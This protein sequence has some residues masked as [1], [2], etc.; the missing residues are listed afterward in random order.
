MAAYHSRLYVKSTTP[1][2]HWR[3]GFHKLDGKPLT[4][5]VAEGV[6]EFRDNIVTSFETVMGASPFLLEEVGRNSKA[7]RRRSLESL[8]AHMVA[9]NLIAANTAI[10]NMD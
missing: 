5:T 2:K 6:A 4:L 3:I 8:H 7:Q 1:G 9:N 10:F